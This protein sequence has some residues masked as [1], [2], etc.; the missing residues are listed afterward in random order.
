M[1]R[2][3]L[4]STIVVTLALAALAQQSPKTSAQAQPAMC[5]AATVPND[6]PAARTTRDQVECLGKV[7]DKVNSQME[8]RYHQVLKL[9]DSK[10]EGKGRQDF[11]ASQ[12]TW[13]TYRRQ[14]CDSIWAFWNPGTI[15]NSA[16]VMCEIELGRQRICALEHMYEVPLRQR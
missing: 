7:L 13:V 9:W 15:K 1:S 12:E 2:Y 4:V 6:C 14:S 8:S 3:I 16:A 5:P 11:E 10:G